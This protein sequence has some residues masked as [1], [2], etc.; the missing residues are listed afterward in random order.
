MHQDST[1]SVRDDKILTPP[2]GPRTD[3]V[4]RRMGLARVPCGKIRSWFKK[5]LNSLGTTRTAPGVSCDWGIR[6]MHE[7]NGPKCGMLTYP[8]QYQKLF[9]FSRYWPEFGLLVARK[10]SE[11]WG[12]DHSKHSA[13]KEWPQLSHAD[14]SWSPTKRLDFGRYWSDFGL[15]VSKKLS[16]IRVSEHSK[17]NEWKGPKCGMLV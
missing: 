9:D 2:C 8:D 10:L 1:D 12:Y 16:E 4:R 7:S 17:E 14:V 15:L 11:I 13:W 3:P 6:I 5:P